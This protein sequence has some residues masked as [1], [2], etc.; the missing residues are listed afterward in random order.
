[1][2]VLSTNRHKPKYKEE[3]EGPRLSRIPSGLMPHL[4][5]E[6]LAWKQGYASHIN[7]EFSPTP[8]RSPVSTHPLA[9]IDFIY[10]LFLCPLHFLRKQKEKKMVII[11]TYL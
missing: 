7:S 4:E 2:P 9:H 6:I 11:I 3:R 5:V 10:L 8:T 1:M